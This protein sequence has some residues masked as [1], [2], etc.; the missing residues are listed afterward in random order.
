[1]GVDAA[2]APVA[3][4][5]RA[6]MIVDAQPESTVSD[7]V[8]TSGELQPNDQGYFRQERK[9]GRLAEDIRQD[10]YNASEQIT[11]PVRKVD[12][13]GEFVYGDQRDLNKQVADYKTA[14]NDLIN[15]KGQFENFANLLKKKD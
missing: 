13:Q 12:D 1:M 2:V 10:V 11:K 15:A 8:D 14:L 4:P 5:S 9:K 3:T 7:S 6:S